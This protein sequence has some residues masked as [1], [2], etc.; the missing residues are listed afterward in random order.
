VT[1]KHRKS[2]ERIL[3]K[4]EAA[5]D[6]NLRLSQLPEVKDTAAATIYLIVSHVFQTSMTMV[7][8]EIEQLTKEKAK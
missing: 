1:I 3:K 7:D 5:R 2:L 6:S 4:L 8:T